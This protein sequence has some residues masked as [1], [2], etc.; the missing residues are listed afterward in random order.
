MPVRDC[1]SGSP[2]CPSNQ[3][4]KFA[5]P[6]IESQGC[7]SCVAESLKNDEIPRCFF[8]KVQKEEK[9]LDTTDFSFSS[10]AQKVKDW[11]QK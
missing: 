1:M 3:E 11:M 4:S 2:F 7:D 9:P 8:C 5:I 10:F 6:G